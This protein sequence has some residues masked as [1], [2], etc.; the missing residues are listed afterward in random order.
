MAATDSS[1]VTSTGSGTARGI[2][3]GRRL[4]PPDVNVGD[5]DRCPLRGQLLGD[6]A[7]DPARSAGDDRHTLLELHGAELESWGF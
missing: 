7:A 6:R 2:S 5:D 3:G 4:R 1:E